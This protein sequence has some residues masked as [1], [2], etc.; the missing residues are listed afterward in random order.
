MQLD[1]LLEVAIGLVFTWLILSV[2]TMHVQDF[3]GR[4]LQWRAN[5]LQQAILNMLKDPGLVEQIYDEPLIE[6]LGRMDKKGR[7]QRPT[8]IPN[9]TF[10]AAMMDIIMSAGKDDLDVP[11]ESMSIA[12]MRAGVKK[13]KAENPDLARAL[14][15]VLPGL[16]NQ[17]LDVEDTLAK[18]QENIANWFDTVMNQASDWYKTHAQTWAFIIGVTI[19]L[20][21]HVDTLSIT[22]QLWREPTLREVIVAQANNQLQSGQMEINNV[23]EELE[24]LGIPIGWS[25]VPAQNNSSCRWPPLSTN[26]PAISSAGECRELTNLPK[27]GDFW[28]WIVK[29]FGLFVSGLAAMQGAPFWFDLLRKVIGFRNQT[30]TT[31]PQTPATA[32]SLPAPADAELPSSNKSAG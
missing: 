19:S 3:I 28:G 1:A 11:P 12:R 20:I 26:R 15:R 4:V 5:F 13:M 31:P 8:N 6:A 27:W 18:Y 9:S 30:P 29:L 21:F 17:S 23:N 14:E 16:E 32:Q 22:N 10:A 2:A 7:L 24:N 25:T